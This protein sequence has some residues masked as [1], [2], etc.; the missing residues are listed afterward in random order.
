MSANTDP[1]FPITRENVEFGMTMRDYFAAAAMPALI[2]GDLC[3]NEVTGE[4]VLSSVARKAYAVADLM[5][6]ERK[7]S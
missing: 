4:I 5:I 7:K 6:E 2:Q 3:R 1:A